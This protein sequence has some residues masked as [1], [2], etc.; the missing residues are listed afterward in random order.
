MPSGDDETKASGPSVLWIFW[1]EFRWFGFT[2][3]DRV[4]RCRDIRE[5]LFRVAWPLVCLGE[6]RPGFRRLV[7]VYRVTNTTVYYANSFEPRLKEMDFSIFNRK[8]FKEMDPSCVM[9]LPQ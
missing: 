3:I 4:F 5:A 9:W 2:A 7:T 1:L 8:L 6:Y